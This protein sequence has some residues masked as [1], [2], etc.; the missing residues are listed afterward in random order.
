MKNAVVVIYEKD[1]MPLE[2]DGIKKVFASFKNILFF[3]VRELNEKL[4]C[5]E[6][7]LLINPYGL[8]FPKDAWSAITG[9]LEEGGSFL[10]MGG[11]VFGHPFCADETGSWHIEEPQD[12]YLKEM[13]LN[14]NCLIKKENIQKLAASDDEFGK[15]ASALS[16]TDS[17]SLMPRLTDRYDTP[18]EP[19]SS[20]PQDAELQPLVFGLDRGGRKIAAPV[21]VIKRLLGRFAGGKWVFAN[22]SLEKDFYKSKSIKNILSQLI[23]I[24]KDEVVDFKVRPT[25]ATY[26]ADEKPQ[27]LMHLKRFAE[28]SEAF[29]VN[30][31]LYK[32]GKVLESSKMKLSAVSTPVHEEVSLKTKTSPGFY[33]ISAAIEK[34]GRTIEKYKNGFWVRDNDLIESG[35]PL[36]CEGDYFTRDGK[37][38]PVIGTTYMSSESHRKFLFNPNP[39]V[40]EQDFRQMKNMGINTVR[41]G[42]WTGIR[43]IMLDSGVV[44]EFVLR[45]FEAYLHS[46][47]KYDITVIFTFFTFYPEPWSGENPYMSPRSIQAQKE[48]VSAFA[49]RFRNAKRLLWDLINEPSFCNPEFMFKTHPN[50]D[51]FEK[52]AW[53][54][55]LKERHVSINSLASKWRCTSSEVKDFDSIELPVK[56]DFALSRFNDQFI[57]PSIRPIKA[58]EYRLFAEE[59]FT[60]WVKEM[61]RTIRDS[62]NDSLITVGLQGEKGLIEDPNPQI[63]S[64]AIDFTCMH[65][66]ILNDDLLTDSLMAKVPSKPLVI[67][68]TGVMYQENIDGTLRDSEEDDRKIFERKLAYAF[69]CNAA[70]AIH[71]QWESNVYKKIHHETALLRADLS[72]KPQTEAMWLTS[73]FLNFSSEFFKSRESEDICIIIPDSHMFSAKDTVISAMQRSLKALHSCCGKQAY[74]IGENNLSGIKRPPALMILPSARIFSDKAWRKLME[75]AKAGSTLLV[76]GPV[77]KDEYWLDAEGRLPVNIKS[78]PVAR[79]ETVF[80]GDEAVGMTF[81]RDW[82]TYADKAVVEG[83]E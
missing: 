66:W 56:S 3:S 57:Q 12:S 2:F 65:S 45:A 42:V 75:F 17:Y 79:D 61:S 54:K 83:E 29:R 25:M 4:S 62:G 76:T 11:P 82:Y 74:C 26:N 10:N 81:A 47:F 30:V 1:F 5:K 41:T 48:Y 39:Y 23:D 50:Y 64:S 73:A 59:S 36:R 71:W 49:G 28:K 22:F 13:G 58:A 35:S 32:N 53:R 60:T 8:Y 55:W 43:H 44:N 38:F 9:F 24:A 72:E 67:G 80:I 14:H 15:L 16:P 40:W 78:V 37:P 31:Q 20:G 27:L 18:N 63:Y 68:E 33:E 70:G 69:G 52:S 34:N 51:K 21:I 19:G 77:D 6:H 46:A 7:C